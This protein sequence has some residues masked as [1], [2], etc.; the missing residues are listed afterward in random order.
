MRRGLFREDLF[1]RLNVFPIRIPPLRERRSDIPL[2]MDHFLKQ[3]CERHAKSVSGFTQRATHALYAYEWQGNV[4]ELENLIERG[5]ILVPDGEP[6][7]VCHL[8]TSGERLNSGMLEISG[9]GRLDTCWAEPT[10]MLAD[11]PAG[12]TAI[13]LALDRMLGSELSLDDLEEE[14]L[15]AAMRKTGGNVSEASRLLGITRPQ[16]DYRLKKRARAPA[17]GS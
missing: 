17:A 1:Y 11:I 7:D 16:L 2:L 5:V 8:F 3:F 12:D 14:L 15:H 10:H 13:D 6:I 9:E 4:R